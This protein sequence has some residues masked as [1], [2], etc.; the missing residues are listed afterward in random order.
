MQ[1]LIKAETLEIITYTYGE[2]HT[3]GEFCNPI[4]A[5]VE[6]S[7]DT[8]FRPVVVTAFGEPE[9]ITVAGQEGRIY[10]NATVEFEPVPVPEGIE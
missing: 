6:C 2:W 5:C 8:S 4:F 9:P 10:R 3:P 1:I 7:C